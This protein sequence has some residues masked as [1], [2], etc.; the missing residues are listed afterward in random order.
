MAEG[1]TDYGL[2]CRL[3]DSPQ[4]LEMDMI[5]W[6][7]VINKAMGKFLGIAGQGIPVDIL[8]IFNSDAQCWIR[9]PEPDLTS[10]WTALSGASC[11]V[12]ITAAT[13]T[14]GI[15]V[16]RASRHLMGVLGPQR[17]EEFM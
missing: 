2:L 17:G 5:T 8:K 12:N 1:N 13:Q 14:V 9:I 16:I 11:S 7:M 10:V 6:R 4:K 15:R 3:H